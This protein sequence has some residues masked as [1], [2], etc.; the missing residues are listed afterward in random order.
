[1]IEALACG[2]KVLVSNT[3]MKDILPQG[4]F[5][6]GDIEDVQEKIK[7]LLSLNGV[8]NSQYENTS[9]ELVEKQSLKVLMDRLASYISNSKISL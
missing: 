2:A 7:N 5:T 3:S 9:K 4:S 8:E 1:V 6:S